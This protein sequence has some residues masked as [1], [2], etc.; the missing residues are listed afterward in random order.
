MSQNNTELTNNVT[1]NDTYTKYAAQHFTK[2][3]LPGLAKC[4]SEIGSRPE[5]AFLKPNTSRRRF[6][7]Q[8]TTPCPALSRWTSSRATF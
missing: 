3:S 4:Y 8:P 5:Y 2:L 6:M 7:S 1:I